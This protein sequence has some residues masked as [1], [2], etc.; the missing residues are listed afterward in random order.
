[1]AFRPDFSGGLV[2]TGALL[3]KRDAQA[4][5]AQATSR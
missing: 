4:V 2:K 1:V 3:R 5:I